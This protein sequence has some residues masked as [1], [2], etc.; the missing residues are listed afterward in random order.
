[1]THTPECPICHEGR[2]Q[3]RY[4][5]TQRPVRMLDGTIELEPPP[6]DPVLDAYILE[7]VKLGPRFEPPRDYVDE[8]PGSPR[9]GF[10]VGIRECDRCDYVGLFQLPTV[11]G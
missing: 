1:M 11:A 3:P 5:E 4:A 2:L 7:A 10:I 9:T 8:S 6:V